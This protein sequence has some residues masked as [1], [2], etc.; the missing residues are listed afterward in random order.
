MELM[1]GGRLGR[2]PRMAQPT[3][4]FSEPAQMVVAVQELVEQYLGVAAPGQR[5]AD[6]IT[7]LE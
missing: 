1:I 5:F 3:G 6:F 2:H 4:V 7:G